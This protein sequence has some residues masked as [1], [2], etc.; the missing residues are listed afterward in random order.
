M[1]A[2]DLIPDQH[3]LLFECSFNDPRS[4]TAVN[5]MPGAVVLN[6]ILKAH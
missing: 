5:K 6:F 3:S 2:T 1:T 4:A